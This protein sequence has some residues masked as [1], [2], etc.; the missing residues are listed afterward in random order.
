MEDNRM[1]S[2][3]RITDKFNLTSPQPL[4]QDAQLNLYFEIF[5]RWGN[6]IG[7]HSEKLYVV[8]PKGNRAQLGR[9]HVFSLASTQSAQQMRHF[10]TFVTDQRGDHRLEVILDDAEEPVATV[11]FSIAV[12]GRQ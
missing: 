8:G 9:E 3:V 12:E 10:V 5:T 1:T 7:Q 11:W 4:P 6:G 2:L